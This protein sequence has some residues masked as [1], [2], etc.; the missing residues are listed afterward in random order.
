[1]KGRGDGGEGHCMHQNVWNQDMCASRELAGLSKWCVDTVFCSLDKIMLM[2]TCS[3][4]V[5]EFRQLV[6]LC[7]SPWTWVLLEKECLNWAFNWS[8]TTAIPCS[9][10]TGAQRSSRIQIKWHMTQYAE[11][12][13]WVSAPLLPQ[14][15]CY[16]L[17]FGR[18]HA[19]SA[20]SPLAGHINCS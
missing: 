19:V 15:S 16:I 18:Q 6:N 11:H 4:L 12:W 10:C 8:G 13:S 3:I 5:I 1:M 17:W 9:I 2:L 20:L 7:L 14:W